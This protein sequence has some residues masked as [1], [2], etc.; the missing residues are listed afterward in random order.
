MVKRIKGGRET[1]TRL[2]GADEERM[3]T[4]GQHSQTS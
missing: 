4:G 2:G 3:E 1:E